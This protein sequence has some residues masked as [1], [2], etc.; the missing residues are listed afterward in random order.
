[1]YR[2]SRRIRVVLALLIL[3][4][5]TLITVDYRAGNGTALRK[6]RGAAAAVFGP[7]ERAV[8]SVVRPIGNALSTL[9]DLGSLNDEAKKLRAEN[10]D[11][12]N[13]LHQVDDIRRENDEL[14]RLNGLAARGGYKTVRCRV[15]ALGPDN[16]EWTATIDCGSGDGLKKDQTVLN[17]DGLVGKV[18]EVAPFSAQVLLAI[19]PEFT[20][21]GRLAAHGTFGPVTGNGLDPM[22]MEL[23]ASN[24]AVSKGEAIVSRG[25]QGGIVA[26]VPIG[27][28]TSVS[29]ERSVL[30]KKV[31]VR[32][33]VHFTSLDIVGVVVQPPRKDPRN[34][35][36]ATLPPTPKPTP[37]P[38]QAP[39]LAASA[40]PTA[41]PTRSPTP[42]GSPCPGSSQSATPTPARTFGPPSP[43]GS[44]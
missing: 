34:A 33:F 35:V 17:G 3:T 7:V 15:V 36:L 27:V 8:T 39:C 14:R 38:T 2:D 10:A 43:T 42:S 23:L 20:V 4:S 16:F 22:E 26:G 13:Q 6:I 9:G 11:L 18:I 29:K 5:F 41:S 30:T 12:K 37:T 25:V 21:V 32:P 28:V 24:A 19:D 1:V 44:P 31:T 40:S